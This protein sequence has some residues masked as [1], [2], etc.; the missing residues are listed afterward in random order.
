MRVRVGGAEQNLVGGG[1]MEDEDILDEDICPCCGNEMG[2]YWECW[3]CSV[4]VCEDC[5]SENRL[6]PQCEGNRHG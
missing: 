3:N 5:I 1:T 4:M 2:I 6:C